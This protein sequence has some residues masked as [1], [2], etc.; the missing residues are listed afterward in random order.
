[1]KR[2][3]F[4]QVFFTMFLLCG[5]AGD[6]RLH[7]GVG[8]DEDGEVLALKLSLV[9]EVMTRSMAPTVISSKNMRYPPAW[10][11]KD[12]PI[13]II[14]N[15]ENKTEEVINVQGIIDTIRS[16]MREAGSM[17]VL[18]GSLDLSDLSLPNRR[19]APVLD[20]IARENDF[21]LSQ[22]PKI[23][24]LPMKARK[25]TFAPVREGLFMPAAQAIPMSQVDLAEF[26]G[27]TPLTPS[28]W[29]SPA[30]EVPL[31]PPKETTSTPSEG[32]TLPPIPELTL[33]NLPSQQ[34][35]SKIPDAVPVYLIRTT[36][37]P[38]DR[39]S[40]EEDEP[41]YQFRLWV[42]ETGS[43]TVKWAGTQEIGK[44][45]QTGFIDEMG[46][47]RDATTETFQNTQN[48][49]QTMMNGLQGA[50]ETVSTLRNISTMGEIFKNK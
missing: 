5:C 9:A 50:Q 16:V 2:F 20:R 42:V 49:A 30:R 18:E 12:K 24:S 23:P 36:L 17:D 3:H 27:G 13:A 15:P 48:S 31:L 22:L 38:T 29:W 21:L 40:P 6:A 32:I 28:T 47:Y 44:S 4:L 37:L 8:A 41:R 14:V 1:M 25:P 33:V 7:D 11:A 19:K 45:E 34:K 39:I 10:S 26:G 43:N 35:N 46:H